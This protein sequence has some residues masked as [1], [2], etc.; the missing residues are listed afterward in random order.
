MR[1]TI[2]IIRQPPEREESR[3]NRRN[4]PSSDLTYY[5]MGKNQYQIVGPYKE[6]WVFFQN[7]FSQMV[8]IICTKSHL[9]REMYRLVKYV[10]TNWS[11]PRQKK[12]LPRTFLSPKLCVETN[13]QALGPHHAP[14][15]LVDSKVLNCNSP[16]HKSTIICQYFQI[17][18]QYIP[19]C[20]ENSTWIIFT[21]VVDRLAVFPAC[22]EPPL[23]KGQLQGNLA[24][25]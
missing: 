19:T 23:S 8:H 9:G 3:V 10:F 15:S 4:S 7:I 2:F 11:R 1:G 18:A 21:Q 13:R 6:K 20:I 17:M 14:A 12:P 5:K 25:R 22:Q 16:I 24:I